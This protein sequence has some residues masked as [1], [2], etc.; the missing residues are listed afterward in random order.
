MSQKVEIKW[1]DE[2]E[3]HDYSATESFLS[4]IYDAQAAAKYVKQLRRVLTMEFKAK[5]IFRA[6]GLSPLGVSNSHIEKDRKKIPGGQKPSPIFP[7]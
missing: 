2:S 1:L 7:V 6:S 4:L 3:E 5:D